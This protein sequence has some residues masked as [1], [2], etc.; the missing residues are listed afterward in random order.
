MTEI[1][2]QPQTLPILSKLALGLRV[3]S[4]PLKRLFTQRRTHEVALEHVGDHLLKDIGHH[5]CVRDRP[6]APHIMFW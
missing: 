4:A 5:R 2:T 3:C 1:T 6:V